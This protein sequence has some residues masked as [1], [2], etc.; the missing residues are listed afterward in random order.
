ALDSLHQC[1]G[2][3]VDGT[4]SLAV[5]YRQGVRGIR[6][7]GRVDGNADAIESRDVGDSSHSERFGNGCG[8]G[9]CLRRW[10]KALYAVD[11]EHCVTEVMGS[12]GCRRPR[13]LSG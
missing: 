10:D 12:E 2:L 7:N 3:C 9:Y 8:G 4:Q 1:A 11:L 13:W 5:V 6:N